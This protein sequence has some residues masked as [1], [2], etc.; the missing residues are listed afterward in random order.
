MDLVKEPARLSLCEVAAELNEVVNKPKDL[1]IDFYY[2]LE[3]AAKGNPFRHYWINN[4]WG[5]EISRRP[6]RNTCYVVEFD[7]TRFTAFKVRI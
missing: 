7:G 1:F 3:E 5:T 4:Y 2:W 6:D